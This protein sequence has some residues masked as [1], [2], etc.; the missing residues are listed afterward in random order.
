LFAQDVPGILDALAEFDQVFAVIEDHDAEWTKF[1][2]DWA[3]REGKLGQAAPELLA[4][5]GVTDERIQALVEERDQAKRRRDFKRA[6]ALRNELSGMGILL[7][8][9]KEGTRWKRK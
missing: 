7:E 4:T 8:D 3:E 5:R 1:T 2:L 6:D 9:S